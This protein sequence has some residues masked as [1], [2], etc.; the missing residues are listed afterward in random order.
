MN[1]ISRRSL[2]LALLACW[3][4]LISISYQLH[5]INTN[6]ERLLEPIDEQTSTVIE[7]ET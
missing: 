6:L 5:K 4:M 3:F 1:D 2:F 7:M